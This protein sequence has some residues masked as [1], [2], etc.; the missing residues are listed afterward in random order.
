VK[1]GEEVGSKE[2]H[3]TEGRR[4]SYLRIGVQMN[5][6]SEKEDTVSRTEAAVGRPA[7]AMEFCAKT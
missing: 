4:I 6:P 5:V 2:E 7:S 3:Q 1:N